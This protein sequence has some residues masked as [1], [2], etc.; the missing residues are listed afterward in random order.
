M[1]FTLF[2][3]SCVTHHYDSAKKLKIIYNY[4]GI[5]TRFIP[6]RKNME[7]Q[8]PNTG[9][10]RKIITPLR[11]NASTS[12]ETIKRFQEAL[13]NASQDVLKKKEKWNMK[14]NFRKDEEKEEKEDE[15]EKDEEEEYE[16]NTKKSRRRTKHLEKEED[17]EEDEEEEEEDEEEEDEEEEDEQGYEENTKNFR[18]KTEH[19]EKE[20]DEENEEE[21]DGSVELPNIAFSQ[22]QPSQLQSQQ[23]SDKRFQ[24]RSEQRSQ[25]QPQQQSEKQFQQQSEKQPQPQSQSQFQSQSQQQNITLLQ[26]NQKLQ[27]T[28]TAQAEE[29]ERLKSAMQNTNCTPYAATETPDIDSLTTQFGELNPQLQEIQ[30]QNIVLAERNNELESLVQQLKSTT[31]S[32]EP[33]SV[34]PLEDPDGENGRTPWH[35]LSLANLQLTKE[36]SETRS[37]LQKKSEE[38]VSLK[39]SNQKLSSTNTLLENEMKLNALKQSQSKLSEAIDVSKQIKQ[40][41]DAAKLEYVNDIDNLKSQLA[42]LKENSAQLLGVNSTLNSELQ[43]YKK[44]QKEAAEKEKKEAEELAVKREQDRIAAQQQEEQNRL[45]AQQQEAEWNNL[46]QRLNWS[47]VSNEDLHEEY[48]TLRTQCHSL[49]RQH[50]AVNQKNMEVIASAQREI[51]QLRHQ[52]VNAYAQGDVLRNTD[53]S[54][55]KDLQDSSRLLDVYKQQSKKKDDDL[56][57]CRA[58]LRECK[59]ELDNQKDMLETEKKTNE[60]LVDQ[61][62][63]MKNTLEQAQEALRQRTKALQIAEADCAVYRTQNETNK[64]SSLQTSEDFPGNALHSSENEHGEKHH[65]KRAHQEIEDDTGPNLPTMEKSERDTTLKSLL[66]SCRVSEVALRARVAE[67][68]NA[69]AGDASATAAPPPPAPPT[70]VEE[71]NRVIKIQEQEQQIKGLEKE[72]KELNAKNL[73]CSL[74]S[75]QWKALYEN[76]YRD[77]NDWCAGKVASAVHTAE[78]NLN[79]K[80]AGHLQKCRTQLREC[81]RNLSGLVPPVI[82]MPAYTTPTSGSA[83][84]IPMAIPQ[85]PKLPQIQK[86]PPQTSQ[87]PPASARAQTSTQFSQPDSPMDALYNISPVQSPSTRLSPSVSFSTG[88]SHF[89]PSVPLFNIPP[90]NTPSNPSKLRESYMLPPTSPPFPTITFP[91][92]AGYDAGSVASSIVSSPITERPRR[93]PVTTDAGSVASSIVSSPITERPRRVPV[94]TDASNSDS[95]EVNM[96]KPSYSNQRRTR[97]D[98]PYARRSKQ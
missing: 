97:R 92:V 37:E 52:L 28:I 95:K 55:H 93:V 21:E 32:T 56:L 36:L 1:H 3:H 87:M 98:T 18:R 42:T 96:R 50:T 61:M 5:R 58:E 53:I 66:E 44:L 19:L 41:K 59:K 94:T 20:E 27:E 31:V 22:H 70:S 7:T 84:P 89:S 49:L 46:L 24:Q 38:I 63:K 23:H 48:N 74:E 2:V 45:A 90:P 54:N 91:S 62:E 17:E 77:G 83:Q 35:E 60:I 72:I 71:A 69:L 25:S 51:M 6:L 65:S 4:S 68:E 67:L 40:A 75:N 33:S 73:K 81:K 86:M 26:S 43:T 11:R 15:E 14:N 88:V 47:N 10:E 16:E 79:I 80:Q 13:K 85:T 29:I 76:L 9:S 8:K 57:N 64:P 78:T 30:R 82:A 39:N 12:S 34:L